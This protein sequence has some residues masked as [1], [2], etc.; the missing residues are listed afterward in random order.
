MKCHKLDGIRRRLGY[1]QGFHVPSIGTA[2]EFSLWWHQSIE[3]QILFSTKN[4]IHTTMREVGKGEWI[5][6][7]WI[8]KNLYRAEKKR[9]F[10]I[11]CPR[12]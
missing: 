10:G 9:I 2:G 11:G 3:M 8:Y 1:N 4:I 6:A 5:H 12:F 7:S